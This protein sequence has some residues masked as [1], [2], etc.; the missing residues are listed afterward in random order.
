MDAL[1]GADPVFRLADATESAQDFAK[2]DDS[3]LKVHSQPFLPGNYFKGLHSLSQMSWHEGL[4]ACSWAQSPRLSLL[5]PVSKE[6]LQ[7]N[8]LIFNTC[9]LRLAV[10]D[11][12]VNRECVLAQAIEYYGTNRPGFGSAAIDADDEGETSVRNAQAILKRLRKRDLYKF[13]EEF[14][15]P[16]EVLANGRQVSH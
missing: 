8:G 15:V 6:L 7:H 4:R 1:V 9:R 14:L 5:L 12:K 16:Q 10:R 13:V 3:I 11:S 2:L